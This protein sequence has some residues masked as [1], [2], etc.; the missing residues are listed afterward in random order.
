MVLPHRQDG[1]SRLAG[2]PIAGQLIASGQ[3]TAAGQ[4]TA[5]GQLTTMA[6]TNMKYVPVPLYV[7]TLVPCAN[8]VVIN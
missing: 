3:L 8:Y 4:L 7:E 2:E 6:H 5:T 1:T